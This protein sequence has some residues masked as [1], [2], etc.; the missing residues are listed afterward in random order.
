MA[1][2]IPAG[3]RCVVRCGASAGEQLEDSPGLLGE[4]LVTFSGPYCIEC[5]EVRPRLEAASSAHRVPLAVI[6]IKRNPELALK[7][8]VRLTPTTLVVG[9][10]GEVREGWLGTPPAGAVEAAL[11]SALESARESA[12]AVS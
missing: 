3:V 4:P 6:D 12:R 1:Q 11:E 7:Y 2:P 8:D 10:S 5:E 9:R